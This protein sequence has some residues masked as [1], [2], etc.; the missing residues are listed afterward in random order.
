[1]LASRGSGSRAGYLFL[2]LSFLMTAAWSAQGGE[3]QRYVRLGGTTGVTADWVAVEG[4]RFACGSGT[5]IVIGTLDP[6][7]RIDRR[8]R[9]DS[10]VH[11]ARFVAGSLVLGLG[12]NRV[13]LLDAE[14]PRAEPQEM[15]LEGDLQV[16]ARSLV[17]AGRLVYLAAGSDGLVV[18]RD[19]SPEALLVSVTVANDFFSPSAIVVDPGDTVQWNNGFGLHNVY[20][21]NPD[22]S[23]CSGFSNEPFDNGPPSFGPWSFSHTFTQPGSNPY[24]CQSHAPGMAGLV[25]VSDPDAG[26]PAVPDGTVG[27]PM[28]VSKTDPVGS[29]LRLTWDAATCPGAVDRQ[30]LW[31]RQL[32][33]GPGEPFRPMGSVCSIAPSDSVLWNTPPPSLGRL[34]WWLVVATDGQTTE[35]PWGQ[36][37]DGRERDGPAPDGSSGECGIAAKDLS[38]TCGL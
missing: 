30:I 18:F 21:C 3:P 38:N 36:A 13:A 20:S 31:G 28:R 27:Q 29:S 23:G 12:S 22:Q 4:R 37:S 6:L 7:P 33:S 16:P 32:P 24:V 34:L 5:E 2:A 10:T 8:L 26:P 14:D 17:V 25:S 19:R 1:M 9:V 15:A 35:G 11:D